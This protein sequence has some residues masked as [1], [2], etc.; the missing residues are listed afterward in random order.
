MKISFRNETEIKTVSDEGKLR[1]YV[2]NI[3]PLKGWLRKFSKGNDERMN[4][5]MFRR[6]TNEKSKN[7]SK[8]NI[9]SFSFG[10]L[11]L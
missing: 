4:L 11:I 6:K 9:C 2:A 10:V 1:G 8:Y 5:E 3:S 7:I